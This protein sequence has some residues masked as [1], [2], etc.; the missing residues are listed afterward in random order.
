MTRWRRY[1]RGKEEIGLARSLGY[2]W[3]IVNED[4]QQ[5]EAF[6]EL[7]KIVIEQRDGRIGRDTGIL[8]CDRLLAEFEGIVSAEDLE[9]LT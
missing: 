7:R 5:E 4:G 3:F 2:R 8:L 1:M 6:E 9:K